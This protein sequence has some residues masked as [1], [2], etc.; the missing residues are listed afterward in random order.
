MVSTIRRTTVNL[1]KATDR[2][3]A[4][5]KAA[6]FGDFTSIVRVAVDRMHSQERNRMMNMKEWADR[7]ADR[8]AEGEDDAT[9]EVAEIDGRD[10]LFT[11]IADDGAVYRAWLHDGESASDIRWVPS[12]DATNPRS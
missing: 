9:V 2:Q 4:D 10:V 7:M 1:T 11:R 8:L 5:L 6:G 12:S 3:V